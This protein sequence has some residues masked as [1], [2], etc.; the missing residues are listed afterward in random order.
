[1]H[2]HLMSVYPHKLLYP[3]QKTL[4]ERPAET[5]SAQAAHSGAQVT[6]HDFLLTLISQGSHFCLFLSDRDRIM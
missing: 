6:P 1:M 4:L 3:L 5:G 2:T